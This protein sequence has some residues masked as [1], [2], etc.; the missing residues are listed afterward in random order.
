MKTPIE[1]MLEGVTWVEN[2]NAPTNEGGLP[3]ATH[4]GVFEIL[5]HTMRC[6]RLSNG[7]TVFN[8][9][10]FEAFF[11]DLSSCES[12]DGDSNV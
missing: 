11:S 10:D 9:D 7:Q 1:M 12:R 6:Y 2:T 3:Y 4:E 5:G 8:A